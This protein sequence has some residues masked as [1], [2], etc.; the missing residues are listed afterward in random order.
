MIEVLFVYTGSLYAE[1]RFCKRLPDR[2]KDGQPFV[3]GYGPKLFAVQGRSV[4]APAWPSTL[5]ALE[6]QGVKPLS[7]ATRNKPCCFVMGCG[8]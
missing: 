1:D 7:S 4:K 5:D 2:P 6:A 3:I 8:E